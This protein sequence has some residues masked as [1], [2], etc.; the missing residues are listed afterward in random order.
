ML[1]LLF[2]LTFLAGI[3]FYG[4]SPSDKNLQQYAHQSEGMIVTFLA[5][6]Q[7][8]KDY[9]YT[10][11]G[12]SDASTVGNLQT[13]GDKFLKAESAPANSAF[14]FEKM[15][16]QSLTSSMCLNNNGVPGKDGKN[17]CFVSKVVPNVAGKDYVITYGGWNNGY[18]RPDWWPEEGQRMR[19]F[20]SWRK[21][22]ANRTR[23]SISCGVL[24]KHNS[25]WC[26]DNGETALTPD[27]SCMTTVP[28][29]VIDALPA[30]YKTNDGEGLHDLL[31][32]MTRFTPGLSSYVSGLTYF[33]DGLSNLD[34]G[35]RTTTVTNAGVNLANKSFSKII[36][37]NNSG[38]LSGSDG[39]CTSSG[40]CYAL[41]QNG[42]RIDTPISLTTGPFTIT[43]LAKNALNTN[44][45]MFGDGAGTD[46]TGRH[47][48]FSRRAG[49]G[50]KFFEFYFGNG[51]PG[52]TANQ[53][54]L[55]ESYNNKN[56][57]ISWTITYDGSKMKLYENTKLRQSGTIRSDLSGN[58]SIWVADEYGTDIYGIRAYN[59]AL[60]E[61]EIRQNFKVDQKRFGI[62]DICNAGKG[63]YCGNAATVCTVANIN[64]TC[65]P[66]CI[67]ESASCKRRMQACKENNPSVDVD[68]TGQFAGDQS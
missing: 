34:F 63:D 15:I 36:L 68:K 27:G 57:L 60:G 43:V 14:D 62:A 33:Y 13:G 38:D 65:S 40:P 54:F 35:Q 58:F 16:P 21:A 8:A 29:G 53:A 64:D 48:L 25:D 18:N 7:A 47:I 55:F 39:I 61:E 31:F 23:G 49:S 4:L 17:N 41:T 6:H 67:C 19:R 42:R 56:N 1:Y 12:A 10:W 11:L 32:C 59:S 22:I 45:V 5:Q 51:N 3:L 24:F 9:L 26:I 28:S 30:P 20:E 44:N 37:R 52:G 2:V 66:I 46:P 50:N